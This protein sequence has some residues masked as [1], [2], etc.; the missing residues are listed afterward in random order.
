MDPDLSFGQWLKQCRK[1]L[2]LTQDDLAEKI[3]CA[4]VTLRKIEGD[5]IRPSKQLADRLAG[6]LEIPPAERES[7]VL[8]SRGRLASNR[9][10]TCSPS[11]SAGSYPTNLLA[12]PTPLIGREHDVEAVR[13]VLQEEVRLLTL[14]GP[15]GIGKTRLSQQAARQLLPDFPDGAFFVPLAHISDPDLVGHTIAQTL[16][17][18]ESGSEPLPETLNGFVR[19]RRMLLLRANFEQVVSAAPLV[20]DLLAA[21]PM[22]KVLATS[23]EV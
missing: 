3:G 2:D 8:L 18:K 19:D 12:S 16:G 10:P 15:P 13:Q 1:V 23:R 5:K 21:A 11:G 20:A 22:L 17:V 14:T 6:H 9:T 4:A 7:F